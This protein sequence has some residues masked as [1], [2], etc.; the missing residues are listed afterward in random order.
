[1]VGRTGR[2][3][4]ALPDEFID[5]LRTGQ[6]VRKAHPHPMLIL[7]ERAPIRSRALSGMEGFIVRLQS[8]FRVVL[9]FEHIQ[10]SIAVEVDQTDLEPENGFVPSAAQIASFSIEC[11]LL[12]AHEDLRKP[13]F[14]P[15]CDTKLRSDSCR[16]VTCPQIF[17]D[18][19]L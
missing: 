9:A 3:P 19:Q 8:S 15:V 17:Y 6:H 2:E 13:L 18:E 16:R 14:M 4:L 7:G 10:R 11:P 1:V 12:Q 5:A